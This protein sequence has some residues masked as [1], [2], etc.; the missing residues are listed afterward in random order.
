[1]SA[2]ILV[3]GGGFAGM[4]TV[5]ALERKAPRNV[6][7]TL[8][9]RENYLLFTPMLPEVA[10]GSIEARHI[11]QPLRAGLRRTRFVL[12]EAQG[13]DV[14]GR[15]V[16]LQHPVLKTRSQLRFDHLII[17]LGSQTSTFGLPG[18]HEH[19]VPLKTLADA[20]ELRRRIVG[21][22]E[23]AAGASDRVVR[24]RFL[25]FVIVGG[26]FTGVET[27]GEL[28]G[29]I[30]NLR[31]YYP[32]LDGL[33]PEI[34]VVEDERQLLSELPDR[35]GKRAALSLRKRG[36]SLQFGERVASAD[37]DGLFLQSGKRL[38]SATIVWTAGVQPAPAV[39]ELGLQTS[40]K[41][42]LIVNP[43]L[44]VPGVEGIWSVGDCAQVPKRS[45]GSYAPL[46]QNAVREG[47][48]LA[49]NLLASLR[50]KPTRP[51]KYQRLGMMASLGDRDA[52]A[53]LPGKRML[54]G[55][56]A[57]LLWRSYYL[58]RLPGL[59]RKIRVAMDWTMSGVFARGVACVSLIK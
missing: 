43:D 54:S 17:A 22:F 14:H 39:K 20:T 42:A 1:M 28:T 38:E 23:A 21:A 31:R 16:T 35:F 13:I 33:R 34:I 19:T 15:T 18:I 52:V 6:N 32:S 37:A 41:G 55:L 51:F 26:G 10:S 2:E 12:G 49:R 44:S 47:P 45:G 24:D 30:R 58:S 40:K 50:G 53:E 57:W 8:V 25:R 36:V 48:H 46:A 5:H 27:A 7:L 29:F 56:P 11:V 3:L 59:P 9:S 4:S